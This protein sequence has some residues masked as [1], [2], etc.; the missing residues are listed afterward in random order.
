[1]TSVTLK[2]NKKSDEQMKSEAKNK[3]K[4]ED[5]DLKEIIPKT[6][7]QASSISKQRHAEE[8]ERNA[9]YANSKILRPIGSKFREKSCTQS[10][11]ASRENSQKN[12]TERK[13]TSAS[14]TKKED[15]LRVQEDVP[16]K[17]LKIATSLKEKRSDGSVK[18][19]GDA[20][21]R[22]TFE[23]GKDT[24][25]E[26]DDSGNATRLSKGSSKNVK[27]LEKCK[28]LSVAQKYMLY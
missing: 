5:N 8:E 19:K 15:C 1:M 2:G 26:K 6:D 28:Y 23:D 14:D 3:T 17:D 20:A 24:K 27:D 18:F 12:V 21:E 4:I 13:A 25:G 10:K 11:S 22:A 16:S 9:K 7:G